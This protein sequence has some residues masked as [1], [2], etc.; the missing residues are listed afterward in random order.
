M[1]DAAEA[2]RAHYRREGRL[3]LANKLRDRMAAE[4]ETWK[5]PFTTFHN[6]DGYMSVLDMIIE[7]LESDNGV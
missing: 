1:S 6:Y 7:E 4:M 5:H 2:V 3:D